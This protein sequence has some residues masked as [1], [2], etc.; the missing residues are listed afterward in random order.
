MLVRTDLEMRVAVQCSECSSPTRGNP[1]GE[2][3]AV[4]RCPHGSHAW[5]E[6][7]DEQGN[8]VEYA[9]PDPFVASGG[10][11]GNHSADGR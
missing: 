10:D 7:Y 11:D 5:V 3:A 4:A 9:P 6:W 2:V 8:R 1:H